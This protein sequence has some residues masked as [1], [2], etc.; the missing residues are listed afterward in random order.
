MRLIVFYVANPKKIIST[1]KTKIKSYEDNLLNSHWRNSRH[2]LANLP[3]VNS[4]FY[5]QNIKLSEVEHQVGRYLNMKDII[6][7]IKKENIEG[8]VLEFGTWQ[9]LSLLI[10]S[11]LFADSNRKF[12]GIDSFE[13]LPETSTIWTKG[14][15]SNTTYNLALQNI[16][17]HCFNKQ[18]FK[19][20]KGW[21]NDKS[22]A[23]SLY[24][25]T[26]NICLI[27]FDADLGS[28]TSQALKIIEPY[29]KNRNKP[30]YFLFDD[31]GCHQD[32]VPES[33]LEWLKTKQFIYNF[34]AHKIS[35]TR[36]TRYYKIIYN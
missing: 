25:E 17:E 32:E 11:K 26:S 28:S 7:E 34:S 19:L 33:F 24:N 12:I 9:G 23:D 3:K 2:I 27:H 14:A 5:K 8:D 21:F 15:F 6:S 1:Y 18:S 29:L 13:G 35:T 4:E 22:V 30:I 10:L 36:L 20:I 31:W 16:S